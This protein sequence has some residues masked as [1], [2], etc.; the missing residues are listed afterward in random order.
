MVLIK[1]WFVQLVLKQSRK[2]NWR[3]LSKAN[4]ADWGWPIRFQVQGTNPE[5]NPNVHKSHIPLHCSK[6]YLS[7]I[8]SEALQ[9]SSYRLKKH[10]NQSR[11]EQW[12]SLKTR[13]FYLI[14][15][16]TIRGIWKNILHL[17]LTALKLKPQVI[18][19]R[20]FQIGNISPT[21]SMSI[22]PSAH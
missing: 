21:F 1:K 9:E 12:V 2:I 7:L 19:E 11:P 20:Y 17:F 14:K 22:H 8:K 16:K 4:S 3:I 15:P 13:K 10:S 6:H 5:E 18:F